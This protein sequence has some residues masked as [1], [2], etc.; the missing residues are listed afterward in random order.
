MENSKVVDKRKIRLEELMKPGYIPFLGGRPK[1]DTVITGDDV[2]N[3]AIA[4]NTTASV[5]DFIAQI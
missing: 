3:V 1:R 2:A 5:K 4:L